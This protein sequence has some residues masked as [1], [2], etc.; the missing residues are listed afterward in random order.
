[1]LDDLN[2]QLKNLENLNSSEKISYDP[3][4]LEEWAKNLKSLMMSDFDTRRE[5]ARRFVKKIEVHSDRTA[6]MSWDPQ[7]ILT[8]ANGARVPKTLMMV[9]TNGCGGWI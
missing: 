7:A 9:L 4:K 2:T 6:E 3:A 8:L 5:M 1:M